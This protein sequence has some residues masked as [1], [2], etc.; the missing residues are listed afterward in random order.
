MLVVPTVDSS[1]QCE[2]MLFLVRFG[3]LFGTVPWGGGSPQPPKE[4]YQAI[5]LESFTIYTS[6]QWYYTIYPEGF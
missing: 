1:N 6:L 4:G 2:A 3:P 5:T